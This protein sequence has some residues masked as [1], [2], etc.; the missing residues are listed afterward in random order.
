MIR[1]LLKLSKN[2]YMCKDYVSNLKNNYIKLSTAGNSNG[3]K[4]DYYFLMLIATYLSYY[5]QK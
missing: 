1:N 3:K 5:Y 4:D 2:N